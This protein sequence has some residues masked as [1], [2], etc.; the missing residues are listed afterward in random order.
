M[1]SPVASR[2]PKLNESGSENPCAGVRRLP[3]LIS[4]MAVGIV[5]L[6]SIASS[7]SAL[8]G[9]FYGLDLGQDSFASEPDWEAI[10]STGAKMIHMQFNWQ[11]KEA[12]GWANTYDRYIELAVSHGEEIL[13]YFYG[14]KDG[15]T[16]YYTEGGS[17]SWAEYE[18]TFVTEAVQ[19]YGYNGSF[20]AAHPSLPKRPLWVW[21]V[22][23]EPNFAKNSANG[24]ANGETYARFLKATSEAITNAQHAIASNNPVVLFG[25]IYQPDLG[26]SLTQYLNEAKKVSGIN[27][28]YAGLSIHPYGFGPPGNPAN[29]EVARKQSVIDNVNAARSAL[30]GMCTACNGKSLWITEFGWGVAAGV[31]KTV[32]ES[33]QASL[34]FNTYDWLSGASAALNIQYA[35]WYLYKDVS[36]PTWAGY[37]GLRRGTGTLRESW[38]AYAAVTA[39]QCITPYHW[40]ADNLGGSFTSNP[41]ISSWGPGRLDIFARGTDGKLWHKYWNYGSYGPWESTPGPSI[42]GGPGAVS[43]G[44]GR[45][46]VVARSA[47]AGN[48]I[49]HWYWDGSWH[50]DSLGGS[51]TSDPDISS[52]GPGRLDVFARGTDGKLWHK[53][54]NYG[55]WS[56]WESMG[57]PSI[58]GGPGAVS[59]GNG[60]I[61]VVARSAEAGNPIA[62]WY[63]D[64]SWHNDSLG[65]SFTS[66]P[67]LASTAP[68]RLDVF[69]RGTDGGIWRK[70][71]N[72]F[73]W[74][75][76]TSVGG[77]VEGGPGA[78]SWDTGVANDEERID[79]VAHATD[80]NK[81]MVHWFWAP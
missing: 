22:W 46:D 31:P 3:L 8:P 21:E 36:D 47:E 65:G 19:R 64:G 79:V 52:W 13:P 68:N 56:G 81:S 75:G 2:M 5:L 4:A 7:A 73:G 29:T 39:A 63:W 14:R 58:E 33:E 55:S 49:A 43:W 30:N 15:S 42:E 53:Y 27:S 74:S 54:W 40:Y 66:D 41:D 67:D 44:N 71:W 28:Y 11:L 51:F 24:V 25:G 26:I 9:Q 23:N 80:A 77:P 10:Q 60:R 34:L 48:P 20:W 57:G 1:R 32:T 70:T 18:A 6:L 69:A 50:N 76:W 17:G 59:W 72:G 16:N 61:D 37:A 62:H 78:V 12:G 38:C 45:I 35:S